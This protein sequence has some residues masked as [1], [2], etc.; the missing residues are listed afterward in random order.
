[1]PVHIYRPPIIIS[2][3]QREKTNLL[4]TS[5]IC[6]LLCTIFVMATIMMMFMA[7]TC[8]KKNIPV[9]KLVLMESK[10]NGS[11]HIIWPTIIA[12]RA[13]MTCQQWLL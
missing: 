1:M 7:K 2:S 4:K 10:V 11:K 5:L 12:Y 9:R 6:I 13:Y 8:T 3:I